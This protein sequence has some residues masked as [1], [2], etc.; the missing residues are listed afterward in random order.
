MKSFWLG[1]VLVMPFGFAGK[2]SEAQAYYEINECQAGALMDVQCM[3]KHQGHL[4]KYVLDGG[5]WETQK[6]V[7]DALVVYYKKTGQESQPKAKIVIEKQIAY[8][9]AKDL[10]NKIFNS[11]YRPCQP[12]PPC[13]PLN[14]D[15]DTLQREELIALKQYFADLSPQIYKSEVKAIDRNLKLISRF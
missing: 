14:V 1:I 10:E 4:E 13:N 15:N 8:Q 12:N 2:A 6:E 5:G 11:H 3:K 7:A 9:H